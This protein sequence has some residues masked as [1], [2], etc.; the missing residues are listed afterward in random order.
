[1][2]TVRPAGGVPDRRDNKTAARRSR[3]SFIKSSSLAVAGGTM[4]GGLSLAR[5]AHPYGDETIRIGVIG[6]GGRG[7]SAAAHAM[8]TS[9]ATRLVAMGD[10]FDDRIQAALRGLS[11]YGDQVD[12]PCQRR[13]VGFDAYVRVLECD[14]DL[15]ILATPPG[16]RPQHFEAAIVAGKHVFAEKP[17]A[18]DA[19][20]V[21]RFLA[22]NSTAQENGLAVA[23]GLQRHH[24]KKYQETIAR[25]HDGAIGEVVTSRA[26]WNGGGVRTRPRR[27]GQTEMEFQM[28]NWYH[29]N[30]LCGDH[31][32]EQHVHNL[33]VINWVKQAYPVLANGHGGREFRTGHEQRQIF[34]HHFVEFTYEDNSRLFSQCRHVQGCWNS[35]SEH[36]QGTTG[37][38]D[39][40]GGK[41]WDAEG[42]QIWRFGKGGGGGHQQEHHDLFAQLRSGEIPNEGEYGAMS[43]MTAILGRMATYSGKSLTMEE[44]MASEIVVSPADDYSSFA[45]SP[46]VLPDNQGRY[47][48]AVPGVTKVV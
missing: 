20:G 34:D 29:F 2:T 45:D 41:I 30:W 35:V 46:P 48:V 7:T 10:A 5:A 6:C 47:P 37:R 11:R 18:V 19:A 14:L 32:C 1:M 43:T 9:G 12:V 22:A 27:E 16:F 33:D 24:E 8:N 13:F 23:V 3:R 38:A 31:I 25:L 36:V 17:V 39:V 28:R 4:L 15:V 42:N 40:S 21:R 44:A 26:Y